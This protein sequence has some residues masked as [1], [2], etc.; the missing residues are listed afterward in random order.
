MVNRMAPDLGR[1]LRVWRSVR[2][3]MVEGKTVGESW[4]VAG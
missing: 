2:R 3:R 1:R 4:E